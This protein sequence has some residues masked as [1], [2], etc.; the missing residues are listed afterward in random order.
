[1]TELEKYELVNSCETGQELKDA[2]LKISDSDNGVIRGRVR[3]FDGNRMAGYVHLVINE[4][5]PANLLTRTY[6]I[7]QQAIYVAYSENREKRLKDEE[8]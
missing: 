1:M 2:M 6:G 3:D 7:R 5:A 8:V 4:G